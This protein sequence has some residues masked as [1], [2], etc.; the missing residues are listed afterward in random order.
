MDTC[1][2][3]F[4]CRWPGTSICDR[5]KRRRL[6]HELGTA[7]QNERSHDVE[8]KL[9]VKVLPHGE[10]L[11]VPQ[12][13]TEGAAGLDLRAAIENPIVVR[14][15][16]FEIIPCGIAVEVP[17]GF[18]GDVRGRGGLAFKHGLSVVHGVGTVD[19]DYRGEM[20]VPLLNHS[21]VDYVIKR[22][23]RIAQLVILPVQRVAVEVVEALGETVRGEGAFGSTGRS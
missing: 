2:C 3:C 11:E 9:K 12:Y 23:D 6:E 18:V 1:S 5:D 14:P 15:H 21:G 22:G 7:P 13:H 20:M 17:E 4:Q 10:G 8:A 16:S 19:W